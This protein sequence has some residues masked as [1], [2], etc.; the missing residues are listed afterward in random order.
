MA[1]L[2]TLFKPVNPLLRAAQTAFAL[3]K[4]GFTWLRDR[5]PVPVLL[6]DTMQ[7]LGATYVKLGQLIASS[8]SV[9]PPEY[10]DAFQTCLDQTKPLP[11][12]VIE[13]VLQEEFG[14]RLHQ[15]FKKIDPVP[16]ASASIAQVHGAT[17]ATGEDVV[18]KVQKPGVRRLFET[19]F[20]FMQFG[21]RVVEKLAP[22]SWDSSMRD[23]VDEIR[24]GMIEECDFVREADN[25]AQY[26]QFLDDFSIRSVVVPKVYRQASTSRVLTM[27]RF[28]GAPLSNIEA[29][30]RYSESPEKTLIDALNVWFQ[31]LSQCQIYHADLHAGNVMVLTN[32]KIGFIDFGIV[33]HIS[34]RVW[35][36]LL[37]LGQY[38]PVGDFVGIAHSLI[39]IGATGNKV[40]A[41]KFADDL[42][43]LYHSLMDDDNTSNDPEAFWRNFSLR[44]SQISRQYGIRFPREFTLLVKQFL[45][46]DRYVRIL[47]PELDMFDDERIDM[48]NLAIGKPFDA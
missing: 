8:P 12:S 1:V 37:S 38:V 10:V 11:Y 2:E 40:D 36:A 45:Y 32:G 39:G 9:F 16:L 21:A 30:K 6:R 29:V 18:I 47:A 31:S 25:I 3:Q 7:E 35:A 20:Q 14:P 41:E 44:I 46:F 27:E 23:I 43:Q 26:Q 15:L 42:Q 28:Y 4:A 22:K 33:G 17:L 13:S 24:N 19:D 34:P 5:T 48:K